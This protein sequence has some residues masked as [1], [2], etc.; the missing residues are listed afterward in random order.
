MKEK[1][2]KCLA[3]RF[4]LKE[5]SSFNVGGKDYNLYTVYIY[6]YHFN[7]LDDSNDVKVY[8][9]NLIESGEKLNLIK[10]PTIKTLTIENINELSN[11]NITFKQKAENENPNIIYISFIEGQFYFVYKKFGKNEKN[12]NI[13]NNFIIEDT[14]NKPVSSEY[15][16]N[17]DKSIKTVSNETVS[18][19]TDSNK[20]VSNKTVSNENDGGK[21]VVFSKFQ[22]KRK[23]KKRKT[24]GRMTKKIKKQK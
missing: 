1:C 10:H 21:K 15:S 7:S 14:P 3:S 9:N 20:T 5:I 19:E 8:Y 12:Q 22:K 13:T 16:L 23:T 24:K 4:F 2:L 6:K 18:N 11:K 17:E